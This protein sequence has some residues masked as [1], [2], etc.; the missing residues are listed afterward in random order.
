MPSTV[1]QPVSLAALAA[2]CH[3]LAERGRVLIGIVGAP[4]AGKSTLAGLLTAHLDITS[5]GS[6]V[7]VPLDGFHLARSVIDRDDRASR[8]GAPDTFDALGYAILLE[9]IREQSDP[10]STGTDR[11]LPDADPGPTPS[12][13]DAEAP[14]IYA[15]E[16][17]RSV[18]D[19]IAGAIAI[20]PA[21]RVVIT[22][23]NYLLLPDPTWR[24]ARATLDE[25]WYLEAPSEEERQEHL[26]ARHRRS[27]KS[28]ELAREFALTSDEANAQ[29]IAADRDAADLI[30]RWPSWPKD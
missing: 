3:A 13:V 8:R 18:G 6:N 24:R 22:E 20:T 12:G 27:G 19:P 30:L 1:A 16:F 4:G 29:L 26:I 9:R 15:P 2:R 7:V 11:T 25:V 10:A 17:R 21:A 14:T 5:P 28:P 23:G